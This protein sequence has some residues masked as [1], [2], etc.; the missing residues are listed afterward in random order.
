MTISKA[1]VK[2][3]SGKRGGILAVE[4]GATLKKEKKEKKNPQSQGRLR[5]SSS[6]SLFG[7]RQLAPTTGD[8][9]EYKYDA[10]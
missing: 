10:M 9:Y 6:G 7:R 5:G 2:K 8:R 4:P 1:A 3:N